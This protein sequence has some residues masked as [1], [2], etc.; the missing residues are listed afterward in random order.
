[1]KRLSAILTTAIL[2]AIP[3]AVATAGPE[4]TYMPPYGDLADLQ[5]ASL[6]KGDILCFGDVGFEHQPIGLP[7]DPV[8]NMERL[9][10]AEPFET[11]D[12]RSSYQ[13]PEVYIAA[14]GVWDASSGMPCVADITDTQ[15]SEQR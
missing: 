5:T 12:P 10:N 7:E 14:G 11:C 13:T 9:M 2:S 1:M 3:A 15:G 6:C 4:A 8:R